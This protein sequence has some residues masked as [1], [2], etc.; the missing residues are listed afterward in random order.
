MEKNLQSFFQLIRIVMYLNLYLLDVCSYKLHNF[1]WPFFWQII[2]R[3]IL[4][5]MRTYI[6]H[7][8]INV[9]K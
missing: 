5:S 6:S 7:T 9:Y 2:G 3:N 1:D 4:L 8:D